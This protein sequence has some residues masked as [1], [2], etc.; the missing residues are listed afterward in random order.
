MLARRLA[1]SFCRC[2]LM[3]KGRLLRMA[4]LRYRSSAGNSHHLLFLPLHFAYFLVE[5]CQAIHKALDQEVVGFVNLLHHGLAR[6]Q[7]VE[8]AVVSFG[9]EQAPERAFFPFHFDT[10]VYPQRLQGGH[11]GRSQGGF[12]GF[13]EGG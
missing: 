3:G 12:E 10:P 8:A 7:S 2:T 1:I 9:D 6:Q 5:G 4:F 13:L 11:L